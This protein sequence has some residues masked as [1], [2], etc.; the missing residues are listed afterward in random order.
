ML[1][2]GAKTHVMKKL[3]NKSEEMGVGHKTNHGSNGRG[4]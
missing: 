2:M 3:P 4:S 1:Q